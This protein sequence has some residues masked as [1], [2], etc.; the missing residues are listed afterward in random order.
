MAKPTLAK[1]PSATPQKTIKT[2]DLSLLDQLILLT[3]KLPR[4]HFEEFD[5]FLAEHGERLDRI[6]LEVPPKSARPAFILRPSE[7]KPQLDPDPR[8]HFGIFS[9]HLQT[10]IDC[11]EAVDQLPLLDEEN[12]TVAGMSW[13][14]SA[15]TSYLEELKKD[16]DEMVGLFEP[17]EK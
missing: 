9:R 7:E 4:K 15:V 11:L 2:Q 17:A 6:P 5:Q 12:P 13:S 3:K 8:I 16:F 1:V 10:V 14:L